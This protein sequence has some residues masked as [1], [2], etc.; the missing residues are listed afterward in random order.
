M[1]GRIMNDTIRANR[2]YLALVVIYLG[3]SMGMGV[4]IGIYY[5]FFQKALEIPNEVMLPMIQ[6]FILLP[7]IAYLLLTRQN[8]IEVIGFKK[9]KIS[10]LLLVVLSTLLFI[11]FTMLLNI[12]SMFFTTNIINDT[13]TALTSNPLWLNL[14]VLAVCPAFCEEFIFRGIL[15]NAYKE[16]GVIVAIIGSAVAFGLFHMNLNQFIYT[17]ILGGIFALLREITGSIFAPMCA[18]FIFN[19]TS[20]FFLWIDKISLAKLA[21]DS[22]TLQAYQEQ[23]A[24]VTPDAF[25][26]LGLFA[27]LAAICTPIAVAIFIWIS[28]RCGTYEHLKNIFR[29]KQFVNPQEMNQGYSNMN[30]Q[31]MNQG[32]SNMNPQGM[33]QG[34]SNMNPQGMNQGYSNM[35][36][37]GMNQGYSNM[38]PQGMNQGYSNVNS[39]GMNQGYSNV[40][41]QKMNQGYPNMNPQGMNQG[42]PNMNP[43]GM[44]Q[45]Y[46]N[47]NSQEMNQ[48]YPNAN[49]QEMHQEY[50]NA[51]PQEMNQGYPNV[52]S[53]GMNQGYSNVNPQ[54][55]NQDYP[56]MNS[57]GMNQ[58]YPNM[59]S[60]GM[61]QGY[62][63]MNPQGMNQ[64]YQ[65]MNPSAFYNRRKTNKT[66][67]TP[68]FIGAAAICTIMIILTEITMRFMR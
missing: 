26:F 46:S 19:G 2:F 44:N 15:Y 11:P 45:D 50:P 49:S 48:E 53:Q 36:P 20:A 51:N 40:D 47:V 65:P 31:G 37:Q 16:K 13:T 52:N 8:I 29:R 57:Q 17:A 60:Q 5:G 22:E 24:T 42:Y 6:A 21:A 28:K 32:Y 43:Q 59:N 55:M 4:I 61:N 33:N 38:N 58:G 23:A 10:T 12:I 25:V 34:Y 62:P 54:R 67:I 30:P 7:G 39:Q 35:N 18:H 41:L 9:I 1:K 27:V 64:N 68:A 56:S 63:N 3:F 66:F 14:I